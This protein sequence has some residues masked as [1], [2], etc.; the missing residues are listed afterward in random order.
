[1]FVE[2]SYECPAITQAKP[3]TNVVTFCNLGP[4]FH[5]FARFISLFFVWL[6]SNKAESCK[7]QA[8]SKENAWMT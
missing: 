8:L 7:Q 4:F 1:M 3:Y 6:L 2:F 5:T